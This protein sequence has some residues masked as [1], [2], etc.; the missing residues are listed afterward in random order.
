MRN[1]RKVI[2]LDGLKSDCIEK[3]MFILRD[4]RPSGIDAVAE[5]EQI[6]EDYLKRY[7]Y[8][9]YSNLHTKKS[10]SKGFIAILGLAMV[11]LGFAAALFSL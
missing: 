2:I 5:A 4:K 1:D 6:V 9:L 8:S 7:H 10:N 3:V 11:A